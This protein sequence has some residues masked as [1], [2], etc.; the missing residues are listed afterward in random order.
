MVIYEPQN[1]GQYLFHNKYTRV[2]SA[3]DLYKR[4]LTV[5]DNEGETN[6]ITVCVVICECGTMDCR[7]CV[8]AIDLNTGA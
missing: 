5:V 4:G 2:R 6:I 7:K 1:G 3:E 8:I